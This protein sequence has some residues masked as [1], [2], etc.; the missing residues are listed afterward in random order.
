MPSVRK[1]VFG[2]I[3]LLLTAVLALGAFRVL[4]CHRYSPENFATSPSAP[5]TLEVAWFTAM[6]VVVVPCLAVVRRKLASDQGIAITFVPLAIASIF[7][8]MAT[9]LGNRL[10]MTGMM[11]FCT[12]CGW[13]A[14]QWTLFPTEINAD[15]IR[16]ARILVWIFVAGL[17][18]CQF[19]QQVSY[20]DDLALGYADCGES[21]RLMFN[22][23]TN[24]RE[25]FLRVNPDKPLFYDHFHPGIL[26]FMP[27]WSVWS[28]TKLTIVLQIVAVFGVTLPLYRM[29]KRAFNSELPALILVMVWVLYP[30]TSQFIYSSSYGF[31]W[32]NLCLLLYFVALDYWLSGRQGWALALGIWA[33]LIKE[34]AAIVVGMFGIYM[35]L[36]ER[37][38]VAGGVLAVCSFGYFILATSV[39][40]PSVSGQNYPI[41]RF[42]AGLG[43]DKGEILLSPLTKPRVFWG[44]LFE[45]T[46]WYFGAALFAPL[47]FLPAR[48]PRLL[49]IGTLTFVFCCMN[50]I[51][52]NISF[53]Y[54]AALLLVLFWALIAA[55]QGWDAARR[56][57]TLTGVIVACL[58]FSL[59]LGAHPWSKETLLIRRSPG[60]LASA[61]RF[62]QQ[63]DSQ[64]S[65]Y[66]S[67][68]LGA[69]FINQRYLYLD[70]RVPKELDYALLDLRDSWRGSPTGLD[71]LCRLRAV[72][73]EVEANPALHLAGVDDGLLFYSRTALPLD[74]RPLVECDH[75]PAN[76]ILV[77][78][79]AGYGVTITGV[80]ITTLPEA[81][82]VTT[83]STAKPTNIDLAVRCALRFEQDTFLSGFQPL[84]QGIVSIANWKTNQFYTDDFLIRLPAG[85]DANISSIS[86]DA[87]VLSQSQ[88]P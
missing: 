35:A 84:G 15:R 24:P 67:Q 55:L 51:L 74:P 71:W 56:I 12:A 64:G 47:L 3:C 87:K 8:L 44:Q 72:Q 18:V 86:F 38:R 88:S 40:I 27:L 57:N 68:R 61:S 48:K 63:I 65:L 77:R 26:P 19:W 66:V 85:I 53:H 11:L 36:F 54:Q 22:T 1:S 23:M 49:F 9:Y 45:P 7:V 31:R 69:H 60:R 29:S 81:V 62:R 16:V 46:S 21:A 25:L 10:H 17:A 28:D 76:V 59:F 34:E 2:F 4:L 13:T 73:H 20:L 41:T 80:T 43:H 50:P 30:S 37:R 32:G 5:N 39:L 79:D 52:K 78:L 82:R 58:L 6:I 42:F 33:I 14:W 75:L 83:Y 70:T